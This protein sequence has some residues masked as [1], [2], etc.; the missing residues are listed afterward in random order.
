MN[1]IG[2]CHPAW[3]HRASSRWTLRHRRTGPAL[4]GRSGQGRS[5]SGGLICPVLSGRRRSGLT[6]TRWIEWRPHCWPEKMTREVGKHSHS[7]VI[8]VIRAKDPVRRPHLTSA[9]KHNADLVG[10]VWRHLV[11]NLHSTVDHLPQRV[12]RRRKKGL[13]F[14]NPHRNLQVPEIN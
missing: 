12:Q 5:L 8:V 2:L 3:C 10:V 1:G 7:Q 4:Q 14:L 13:H 11:Q 9:Y 6:R